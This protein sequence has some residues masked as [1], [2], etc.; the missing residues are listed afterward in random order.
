MEEMEM[1][2]MVDEFD[3]KWHGENKVK[4]SRKK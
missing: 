4:N 2:K 1:I 3:N